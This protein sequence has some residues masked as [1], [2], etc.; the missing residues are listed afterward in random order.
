M[1]QVGGKYILNEIAPIFTQFQTTSE[2]INAELMLDSTLDTTGEYGVRLYF[3]FLYRWE[4]WLD[5]A[6]ANNDFYPNQQTK[7]WVPYGTTGNWVLRVYV[8]LVQDDLAYTFDDKIIIKDLIKSSSLIFPIISLAKKYAFTN[9]SKIT[10]N[11]FHFV[12][13]FYI[14]YRI[15]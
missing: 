12:I 3:P 1:P 8:E 4:Y 15:A 9:S 2:K 6:N 5:Q 14:F 10:F 13:I 11:T 7:N